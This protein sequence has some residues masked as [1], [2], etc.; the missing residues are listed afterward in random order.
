MGLFGCSKSDKGDENGYAL[1]GRSG[2]GKPSEKGWNPSRDHHEPMRDGHPLVEGR[3]YD[4]YELGSR[5]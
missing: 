4:G 2:R 5:W 1:G 3:D